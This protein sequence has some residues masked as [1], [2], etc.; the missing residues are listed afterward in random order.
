MKIIK[1]K[2]LYPCLLNI[3]KFLYFKLSNPTKCKLYNWLNYWRVNI[4]R[5]YFLDNEG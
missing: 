2:I 3:E 1:T 4:Y 5:E